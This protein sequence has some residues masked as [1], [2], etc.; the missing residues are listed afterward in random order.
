MYY[1]PKFS[2]ILWLWR[3]RRC[4]PT[5][6]NPAGKRVECNLR[7]LILNGDLYSYRSI[8]YF[9]KSVLLF[10]TVKC[11]FNWE[12]DEGDIFVWGVWYRVVLR[13]NVKLVTFQ[14]Y[15][16]RFAATHRH[17]M[18]TQINYHADNTDVIKIIKLLYVM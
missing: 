12:T 9:F 6:M 18:S 13:V 7:H 16:I 1:K 4:D 8:T 17:F 10:S 15:S 14:S 5:R 2:P 11:D 3:D